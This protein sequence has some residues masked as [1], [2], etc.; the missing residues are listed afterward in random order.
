MKKIHF[1]KVAGLAHY[2]VT[3][4]GQYL[5]VYVS[6]INGGMFK[7]GNGN[8]GTIA[9]KL[10]LE[11]QLNLPIGT[12]PEEVNWVYLKDKLYLKTSNKDPSSLDVYSSTDFK[13]LGTVQLASK[14]LFGHTVLINMNK[15]SILL[16]DGENLYFLGK[17]IKITQNNILSKVKTEDKKEDPKQ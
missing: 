4:D 16:T 14:S 17:R 10:Y 2:S 3:T 1:Q 9:G 12:K 11:K 8:N 6:A 5:Y 7:F 13:K 15:N